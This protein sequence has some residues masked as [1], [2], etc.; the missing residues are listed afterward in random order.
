MEISKEKLL[1]LLSENNYISDIDEMS[2]FWSK[3]KPG[4]MVKSSKLYDGKVLKTT[5]VMT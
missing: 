5:L 3:K 2:L 1:S 4:V